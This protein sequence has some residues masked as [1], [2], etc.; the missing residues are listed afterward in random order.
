[1]LQE[2]WRKRAFISG[3][4]MK[5]DGHIAAREVLVSYAEGGKKGTKPI[6]MIQIL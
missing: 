4:R 2:V 1:M 6:K 3:N 5:S